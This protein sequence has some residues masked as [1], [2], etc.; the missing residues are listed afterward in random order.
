MK[1]F[2]QTTQ[3]QAAAAWINYLNQLRVDAL[4]RSLTAQKENL[5]NAITS[6][7]KALVKI[8]LEVVST[9]RGGQKGM[10]GFIAEIAEVGIGNA[11]ELIHGREAAYTWVNDNGP[12]DLVRAGID[13]QQK[14][15]MSGGRFSLSA[16][17]D[18]LKKYPDYVKNG[19]R[20][21]IPRDHFATVQRLHFMSPEEAGRLA[22]H[23]GEGESFKD[24]QRINR[25]FREAPVGIESL[26]PSKL[27]YRDV[28]RGAYASTLESEK[29]SLRSTDRALRDSAYQRSRPKLEE[30]AK[31]SL[32][33]ATLEGG[34][35]FILALSAKRKAGKKF[36]EFNAQDW[37]EILAGSGL[38]VAR[39][40]VRGVSVYSLSNFTATS[41][42]VA[43]SIVTATFGIAEQ[44]HKL[45][46]G[47]L[48]EFEF[49]ENAELVCLEAAV[50]ALSSF[51]GQALIPVPVIGAL[52]GNTIGPIMYQS[53]SH[54][55][56]KIEAD[57]IN[58]YLADQSVL[59]EKLAAE[60]GRLVEELNEGLSTYLA[61]LERAF[62]PDLQI[63]L[64]GSVELARKLGVPTEE[65]LDSK[66]KTSAYFLD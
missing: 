42:A 4:L 33:A 34:T 36:K 24:W 55:L 18:H 7:N 57:L 45:R 30:G 11:R 64:L 19:G 58:G 23:T 60:Y 46:N 21:Q 62:S 50:A 40:A 28:Q 20:Y 12:V 9:D 43:S 56:S 39:G 1:K 13:I 63:A 6:V 27:D 66:N 29:S 59:D 48:S 22:S 53:A 15:S 2:A 41:A 17:E 25:F 52:I 37:T 26:E 3:E 49:L 16:V 14:F 65:I 8:D 10:H 32:V 5:G 31:A 35:S 44:A 61:V 38:G 54:S 51:I 47:E